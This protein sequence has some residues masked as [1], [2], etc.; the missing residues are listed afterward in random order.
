MS[1][2]TGFFRFTGII[3]MSYGLTSFVVNVLVIFFAIDPFGR[4]GVNIPDL[5]NNTLIVIGGGL[6][7]IVGI[8]IQT[9]ESV[10]PEKKD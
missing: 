1:K 8:V 4:Y 5:V 9:Q 6:M 7:F 3:L 2:V 10:K